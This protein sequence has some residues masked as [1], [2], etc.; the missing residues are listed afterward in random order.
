MKFYTLFVLIMLCFTGLTQ[1]E[2]HLNNNFNNDDTYFRAT[3]KFSNGGLQLGVFQGNG[4]GNPGFINLKE[5]RYLSISTN[6]LE[7]MRIL[8]TGEIGIGI[9]TPITLLDVNGQ[10]TVRTLNLNNSLDRV[11]VADANGTLHYRD[12]SSL[13]GTGITDADWY[14]ASNVGFAPVDINSSIYTFGNVGIGLNN[15]LNPLNIDLPAGGNIA[16]FSVSDR[17]ALDDAFIFNGGASG[18]NT[19]FTVRGRIAPGM[20]VAQKDNG[21]AVR[22]NSSMSGSNGVG[23]EPV[24]TTTLFVGG[25]KIL[26]NQDDVQLG[27]NGRSFKHFGVSTSFVIEQEIS[28]AAGFFVKLGNRRDDGLAVNKRGFII[29]PP[30]AIAPTTGNGTEY[31]NTHYF[32]VCNNV[33]GND[34][35][36]KTL[37]TVGPHGHVGIG[38]GGTE[39]L[40]ITPSCALEVNG[41]ICIPSGNNYVGSDERY[42]TDI[43]PLNNA[44]ESVLK[45]SGNRYQMRINEFPNLAFKEGDHIGLIAQ[46]VEAVYPELILTSSNGF[47]AVN[48]DGIIP[49]LVEAIKEQ[50]GII[51][52]QNMKIDNL[53]NHSTNKEIEYLKT[54]LEQL[55]QLIAE[56]NG[57]NVNTVE[58]WLNESE[59]VIY[60]GQNE[61]NPFKEVT[62]IPYFI[63]ENITNV[64]IEIYSM[65]GELIKS[66]SLENGRGLVKIFASDLNS[67]VYKYSIVANDNIIE[68][69]KMMISQ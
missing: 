69:K 36:S 26:P 56:Q 59:Q 45:L 55:K 65:A 2:N 7:R 49:V 52:E 33:G 16:V 14:D 24:G 9:A 53:Q 35:N 48:Y 10:A 15:P 57:T 6:N 47:K 17:D 66:Q 68:S 60:L 42:K 1:V 50:Q 38:L 25:A 21:Q 8:K 28:P 58:I 51:E 23:I 29:R 30:S 46:E 39:T 19:T 40:P 22:L 43:K 44:L 11:L 5:N 13:I 4:T 18:V 41:D 12:A 32:Q 67:G 20:I 34:P 54:E 63:P 27:Q 31:E 62:S 61:P 37:F 64:R 3:N